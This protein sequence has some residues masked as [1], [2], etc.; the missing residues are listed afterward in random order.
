MAIID[1]FDSRSAWNQIWEMKSAL[2]ILTAFTVMISCLPAFGEESSIP[3]NITSGSEASQNC[4][5]QNSCYDPDI[6]TIQPKTMVI[7]TNIDSTAHTVTSG[8]PSGND[9]G[10]I[11][12]S[13]Q[14]APDAT[15]SFIFMTPGTYDY[16]CSIHPWMTGQVVVS[17]SATSQLGNSSAT[18]EFGP[19]VALVFFISVLT[20]VFLAK[21]GSSFKF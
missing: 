5:S 11:F 12:D 14:I 17:T 9:T 13:G 18:P 15:Y 10:T 20:T 1:T 8:Q 6:I 2:V 16:F 7:W 19:A 21:T 3:V 4:V